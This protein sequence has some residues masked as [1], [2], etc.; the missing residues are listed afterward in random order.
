MSQDENLGGVFMHLYHSQRTIQV[1]GSASMPDSSKAAV[2][3]TYNCL[4]KR[5]KDLAN[6]KRYDIKSL[7]EVFRNSR[8]SSR[9]V[10]NNDSNNCNSCNS[11]FNTK[12]KPSICTNCGLYFHRTCLNDHQRICVITDA[13]IIL[14][15]DSDPPAFTRSSISASI[16]SPATMPIQGPAP[17]V[18]QSEARAV[19]TAQMGLSIQ[20]EPS[21]HHSNDLIQPLAINSEHATGAP[22]PPSLVTNT[23]T[24]P[25][26]SKSQSKRKTQVPIDQELD[27][28]F[29]KR[30]LSLAQA[31]IVAQDA[32][33]NDKSKRVEILLAQLKSYEERENN[34]LYDKYFPNS[35]NPR[36]RCTHGQNSYSSCC[37]QPHGTNIHRCHNLGNDLKQCNCSSD[38]SSAHQRAPPPDSHDKDALFQLIRSLKADHEEIRKALTSTNFGHSHSPPST[39]EE[40]VNQAHQFVINS[41]SDEA[42]NADLSINSIEHL[43][44]DDPT[45]QI[46]LNF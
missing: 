45:E 9:P 2:W 24:N 16:N 43:I 11:I 22:P 25:R 13:S 20:V 12:C 17:S 39:S 10:S 5:L 35:I 42:P 44:P 36:N 33:I 1:Q 21:P 19:T 15:N 4:V 46:N 38:C 6:I 29:L 7:N 41:V 37:S 3:F 23:N 31:R 40:P 34:S 14:T 28:A 8:T 32:E 27:Q 30:E 26:K 18:S